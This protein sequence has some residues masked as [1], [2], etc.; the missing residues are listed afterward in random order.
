MN[1]GKIILGMSGG[2]D[3]SVAAALLVDQGYEVHGITL[4]VWEEAENP[5]RRWQEKS[6]CKVGLARYVAERLGIRHEV[7]DVK[8]RFREA[9]IDD[10]VSGYRGGQTP[11]PCVRCNEKIKF[12][13][14]YEA[15]LARGAEF[16]ATGHY[17]RLGR[18]SNGGHYLMEAVD[19]AKDQSYFLYRLRPEVLPRLMFPLGSYRKKDLGHWI[20]RLGL[21]ADQLQE[22]QEICFVTEG[23][24]REFLK[25]QA[26]GTARPGAFVSAG[27]EKLGEH[28]GIAFYT[29]GQ[30]R[31]LGLSS[32][33]HGERLYVI[34]IDSHQDRVVVG[35]EHELYSERLTVCDLN[36]T[37]PALGQTPQNVDVRYRYRG[38]KIPGRIDLCGDGKLSVTFDAPQRAVSRGQSVVFYR[39]DRVLGGGIIES[40]NP[41]RAVVP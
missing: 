30:R 13:A 24:Y 35:R 11:N 40:T 9:V 23:D 18:D 1:R 33:V 19:Q 5:D 38:P 6:C 2:M 10:F 39:Q 26:P 32:T 17:V 3:S 20:E 14:L 21:P 28:E 7:I 25:Q 31:G 16:L 37:G 12:G 8:D 27:G 29:V 34:G 36:Y 22:S 4:Q 15:A 41:V